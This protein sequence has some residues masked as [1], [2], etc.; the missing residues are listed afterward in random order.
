M[1][2]P[3]HE[4]TTSQNQDD[5]TDINNQHEHNVHDQHRV[6]EKKKK[7]SWL[8][9][10][11]ILMT[12]LAVITLVALAIS[13]LGFNTARQNRGFNSQSDDISE[14]FIISHLMD[15]VST[16]NALIAQ[17]NSDTQKNISQ[18]ME[19]FTISLINGSNMFEQLS[20][21][22]VVVYN[23][24]NLLN[25]RQSGLQSDINAGQ[26]NI[27]SAAVSQQLDEVVSQSFQ[28]FNTNIYHQ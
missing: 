22:Q 19:H 6:I 7:P 18:L 9:T 1:K 27:V 14:E 12:I 23:D 20:Q 2:L 13:A 16:L 4:S 25:E 17:L 15:K 10:I 5:F 21:Q 11:C 28:S 3:A 8:I 24:I 26:M